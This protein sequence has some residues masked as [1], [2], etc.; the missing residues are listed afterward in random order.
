MMPVRD[1]RVRSPR[2]AFV[3]ALVWLRSAH[4]G[5]PAQLASGA[6]VGQHV[7]LHFVKGIEI[8]VRAGRL[9]R[10]G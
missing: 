4:C 7:E 6:I 3:G 9:L 10:H 5:V 8:V 1:R 2:A